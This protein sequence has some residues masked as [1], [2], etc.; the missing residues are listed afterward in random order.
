MRTE[1]HTFVVK[2]SSR[3]VIEV[4]TE[5]RAVY[6][7]FRDTAVAKTVSREADTMHLAVDL[8]ANGEVVGVEAVGVTEFEIG[9]LL[10]KASVETP[11]LDFSKA[12]YVPASL[13]AA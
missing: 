3:F 6:V 1:R 12:R 7:R 4:D 5:A 11:K 10:K 8:D 2:G 9:M 13:V